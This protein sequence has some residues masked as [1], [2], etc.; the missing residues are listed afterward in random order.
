MKRKLSLILALVAMTCLLAGSLYG[1]MLRQRTPRGNNLGWGIT[2]NWAG[3]MY[4]GGSGNNTIQ[5]PNGSGNLIYTDAGLCGYA[6]TRDTNGDG[7]PDDTII[8]PDGSVGIVPLHASIFNYD[9]V[10]AIGASEPSLGILEDIPYDRVWSSSDA[11]ELA[12]WPVEGRIG[13][14]AS[15]DPQLHGAE[16][17][18]VHY[19]DVAT[20]YGYGPPAGVYSGYSFY[21]LDYGENNDMVYVN[22]LMQNVSEYLKFSSSAS[23]GA[24]GQAFPDGYTFNGMMIFPYIRYVGFGEMGAGNAAWAYHP[25]QELIAWWCQDPTISSFNPQEPPIFGIKVLKAPEYNGKVAEIL[26]VHTDLKAEYGVTGGDGL[27]RSDLSV[28]NRYKG[29]TGKAVGFFE[30][31]TNPF[32]LRPMD[33]YPGLL[34]PEDSRYG[35]WLWG[36]GAS[37]GG[38]QACLIAHWGELL[39]IVPRDTIS[40]DYAVM[41]AAP[42]VTP[43]V[44]PQYDIDNIDDPMMQDALAPLEARAQVAMDVFAGGLVSPETPSSPPLTVVPGDRQITITW[45][46]I[47]LRT[48]D[49]FYAVLQEKGWDPD[50]NYIEYDFE[51]YRLYRS[52]VGPNDSH[53]ELIFECSLSDNNLTFFYKDK[54]ENDIPYNRMTNGLK[55]WYSLVAFDIN[56]NVS[57]GEEF[58]LPDPA[59]SKTWNRPGDTGLYQVVPRSEASNFKMA[60]LEGSIVFKPAAGTPVSKETTITLMGNGDGTLAEAPKY[61]EPVT[62]FEFTPVLHERIT[63][64]M[65]LS[66]VMEPN[67]NWV[68]VRH[69]WGYYYNTF[70]FNL[71]SGGSVLSQSPVINTRSYNSMSSA[72]A[73]MGPPAHNDGVD[74]AIAAEFTHLRDGNFRSQLLLK[75]DTGGY[76]GAD[77]KVDSNRG[78][79]SRPGLYPPSIPG[80]SRTGRF[81]I[82]WQAGLT[83]EITD[84]THGNSIPFVEFADQGPGWGFVTLEAFGSQWSGN[85]QL[86]DDIYN[87]VPQA[88]RTAKMVQTLPGGNTE[89]FGIFVNGNLWVFHGTD[90]VIGGMPS[91]GTVML[92]DHAYGTWNGEKTVFTQ[93]TDPP[94]PGDSWEF[95]IKPS[96]TNAEDADFSK[97]RVVPNP[98]MASSFLD[99]SPNH[100][101]I[102]FV[103]LPAKCTVRIYSL[104]GNLVNVLN[105]IGNNRVGWGDYTNWDRMTLS[106]PSEYTG[107]DN[108]GGTEPWNLR[109]R[110]GQLVASGLYFYHVTDERGET[111]TGKFYVIN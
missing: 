62:D 4:T 84:L 33:F 26:N 92:Y 88:E 59:S 108:H 87:G 45:S 20:T 81:S 91:A 73:A 34:T 78:G 28:S 32:T 1:E 99:N 104:G 30:G 77:P 111:Y 110:Y 14:S 79:D 42:G 25:E 69:G 70:Y 93:K 15:G 80:Q 90:D 102:E 109:N 49:S 2:C 56:R 95:N 5:F 44:H 22:V 29:M 98:Y 46:D 65:N 37:D 58:S 60:G 38:V 53:S 39:D 21:F 8:P 68:P 47:N 43:L 96:T 71:V 27:A 67:D 75:M 72:S 63:S 17:M 103:N 106:V 9:E 61:L 52:F 97:I 31:Q 54:L 35:Q 101:R 76:S 36:D 40:I 89:E 19:G 57:N 50:G 7:S 55:I 48:P 86:F 11:A 18:F 13:R 41:F 6:L 3:P 94:F 85:G 82:T 74:Y 107:Y 51:G 100:K 16:T 105:H 12:D 66:I 83:V 10:M 23:Y 64:A 24:L